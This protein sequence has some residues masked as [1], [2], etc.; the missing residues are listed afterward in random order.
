M[1]FSLQQAMA[2]NLNFNQIQ[3]DEKYSLLEQLEKD[4]DSPTD[5]I[6]DSTYYDAYELHDQLNTIDNI[7]MT[8]F[9][10]NCQSLKAHWESFQH[11]L[12]NI[13]GNSNSLDII[14]LTEVFTLPDDTKYELDGYHNF[15][16]EVRKD[17]GRG[18]AGIFINE[19]YTYHI[20][21]DLSVFIP[22]IFE[23]IFAEIKVSEKAKPVI[24]GIIYRPNTAPYAD[25]EIFSNTVYDLLDAINNEHKTAYLM[26][27][28]NIDLL[29]CADHQNTS[30]YLNNIFSRSFV[31]VIT[32]PT[33]VTHHSATLIDHIYTNDIIN[34]CLSAVIITDDVADHF[35]TFYAN[36]KNPQQICPK[37]LTIRKVSEENI[38]H[39]RSELEHT[40]FSDVLG[41]PDP[42]TAYQLFL[43]KYKNI[44]NHH[45]PYKQ[46][47]INKRR[48]KHNPWI[49]KGLLISCKK[50]TK[51]LKKKL[52]HPTDQNIESYKQYCS[53]Y[54]RLVRASRSKY[55]HDAIELNKTNCIII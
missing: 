40:D 31:P 18:G 24:I 11:L 41:E 19:T 29:K 22:H 9:S 2:I 53:A 45:L 12:Y 35:G 54:N 6:K 39:F 37:Y 25:L 36:F 47:K 55:L 51:L 4:I 3:T 13:Q 52:K 46:I 44:M 16:Y 15:E 14:G 7:N 21:H 42:N 34:N 17:S 20:R 50:K 28:F 27:D 26:G 38:S 10:I 43:Q 32:K 30:D 33:R 48:L 23:S 5:L 1:G 49:T 8:M